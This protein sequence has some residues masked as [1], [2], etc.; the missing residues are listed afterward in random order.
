M[1]VWD[2]AEMEIATPGPAV[3]LTTD[4]ATAPVQM[5][6]L[7]EKKIMLKLGADLERSSLHNLAHLSQFSS[8]GEI[9][10]YKLYSGT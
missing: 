2:Q 8:G 7:L 9:F 5:F 3:R 1:K 10:M 6:K 4:C